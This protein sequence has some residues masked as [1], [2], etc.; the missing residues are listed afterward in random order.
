M[1]SGTDNY[2][3]LK[4]IYD[5]TRWEDSPPTTECKQGTT[6]SPLSVW[7]RSSS[8]HKFCRGEESQ[9]YSLYKFTSSRLRTVY[10][11]QKVKVRTSLFPSFNRTISPSGTVS[12]HETR[13]TNPQSS[14]SCK[15]QGTPLFP[16]RKRDTLFL[17]VVT[18]FLSVPLFLYY[19]L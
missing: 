17:L 15:K 6:G 18:Y 8:V 14:T 12:R 16:E 1:F 10:I 4:V 11:I 19:C 13:P 3:T 2:Y 7:F 5:S 9:T